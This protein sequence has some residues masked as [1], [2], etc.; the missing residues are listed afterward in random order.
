V[1]SFVAKRCKVEIESVQTGCFESYLFG[2]LEKTR[3]GQLSDVCV[4]TSC[5]ASSVDGDPK[6]CTIRPR[7]SQ[8]GWLPL[9]ASAR[10]T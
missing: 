5:S 9:T 4:E 1:S 3:S 6:V 7:R 2:N 8:L 10:S